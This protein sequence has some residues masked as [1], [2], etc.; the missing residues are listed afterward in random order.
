[1]KTKILY[2]IMS[3]SIL[4]AN[5]QE[6]R[7]TLSGFGEVRV[8]SNFGSEANIQQHLLFEQYGGR[9][10]AFIEEGTVLNIAPFNLNLLGHLSDNLTFTGELNNEVDEGQLEVRL[11][12]ANLKYE[13]NEKFNL[14]TGLFLTPIGYMN[15]NQRIYSFL[16]Y[17]VLPRDMVSEEHRFIPIFTTGLMINGIF[18]SNNASLKY[19]LAYGENRSF[20]PERSAFTAFFNLAEDEYRGLNSKPGLAGGLHGTL[21]SGELESTLGITGWWNP[22]VVTVL[23]DTLGNDIAYGSN[24]PDPTIAKAREIGVAPFLRI[25][26]PLWQFFFEYHNIVF[27]DKLKNTYRTNYYYSALSA[28]IL[29]KRQ[30][31]GKSFYPYLRF[32]YRDLT[33]NHFYY[34]L[35]DEGTTLHRSFVPDLSEIMIGGC[36]EIIPNN[37]VKLEF[38][39]VFNGTAP[40]NRI[41]LSTSFSF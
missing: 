8:N 38:A 40:S 24:V 19:F 33:N 39:R 30:I 23:N 29:L 20:A 5:G 11:Y 32:D 26:H 37:K 4:L 10:T 12:R 22:E 14:T 21:Y 3:T 25:D 9:G 27:T 16:N 17:S 6:K 2:F 41:T 1:M 36:L 18:S 34:G 15:R 28:E 13:V 7:L 35:Y 31:K